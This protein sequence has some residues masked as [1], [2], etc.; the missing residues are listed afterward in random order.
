VRLPDIVALRFIFIMRA[1]VVLAG[2]FAPR[3]AW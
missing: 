2:S 1:V 3:R